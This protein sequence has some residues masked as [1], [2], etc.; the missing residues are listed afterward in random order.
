MNAEL[1]RNFTIL[2]EV[3]N[4]HKAADMIPLAQPALSR[5][6]RLLEEDLGAT[7]F[8]RSRK[9]ICLTPAGTAFY[10][11]VVQLLG[12]WDNIRLRARQIH[13][14]KAGRLCVGHSSSAMHS[15]IPCLLRYF[16][17][18]SPDLRLTLTEGNNRH[19]L[20]MLKNNQ[21]DFGFLP[22]ALIPD[23]FRG[24]TVYRENYMLI[25]PKDH[26]VRSRNLKAYRN[27]R[28]ILHPASDGFGYMESIR[29]IFEKAGFSPNTVHES[30]NTSSVLRMVAEGMGNAIMGKTTLK[31]FDLNIDAI[32]LDHLSEKLEMKLIWKESRE[33][34]LD[35]YLKQILDF[36]AEEEPFF[37]SF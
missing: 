20:E 6:I 29:R 9:R 28:W 13:E 14:G 34:A 12:Q 24:I 27:D 26:P 25:L 3:L 35:I 33:P 21:V 7:L 23:G 1:L 32:E 37:T 31:G 15:L 22:N 2:A 17:R 36:I 19:V 10:E 30:P 4:Y 16:S 11:E 18:N 8:D 5:Q